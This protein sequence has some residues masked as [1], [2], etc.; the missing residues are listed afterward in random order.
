MNVSRVEAVILNGIEL[1]AGDRVRIRVNQLPRGLSGKTAVIEGF[2]Q[3]VASRTQVVVR[4]E[5]KRL[6][7]DGSPVRLLLT[8]DE[9]EAG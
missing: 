5:E 2:E 3:G 7:A 9:I 1:R 8:L 6:A 4:L